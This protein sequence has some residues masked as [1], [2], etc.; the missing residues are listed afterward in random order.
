MTRRREMMCEDLFECTHEPET[1]IADPDGN[2]YAWQCRCGAYRFDAT[3]AEISCE[4][5]A[6]ALRSRD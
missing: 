4:P 3:D 2:V 5:D 1:A 6:R